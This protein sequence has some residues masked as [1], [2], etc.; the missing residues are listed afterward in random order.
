MNLKLIIVDV[1]NIMKFFFENRQSID[2]NFDAYQL[3]HGSQT[4]PDI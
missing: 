2:T 3:P 4:S 1:L